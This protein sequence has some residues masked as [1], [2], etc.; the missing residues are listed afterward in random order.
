MIDVRRGATDDS[1]ANSCVDA[2]IGRRSSVSDACTVRVA[3]TVPHIGNK[4][5]GGAGENQGRSTASMK[6]SRHPPVT[7]LTTALVSMSRSAPL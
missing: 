2:E 5:H 1:A 7:A 4:S 6:L 3:C